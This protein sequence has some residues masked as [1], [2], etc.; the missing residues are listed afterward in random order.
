MKSDESHPLKVG[1]GGLGAIGLP[2]AR[3]LAGGWPG[4]A[5]A[6]VSARDRPAPD[7]AWTPPISRRR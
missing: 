6:A 1:I 3:W 2:V 5:L 7:S 4:L